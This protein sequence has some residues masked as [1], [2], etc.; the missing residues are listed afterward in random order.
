MSDA[1]DPKMNPWHPMSDPVD[2]KHVQKAQEELGECVSALAR[3]GMQGI[4]EAHPETGKVNRRWLEEEIADA[5]A[6][7]QLVKDH[8]ELD[9]GFI[10]AR[11]L[12]KMARLREWHAMA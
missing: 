6:N 12:K 11:K 4:D 2:L 1:T 7:L 5:E 9:E 3:C 10:Y 8:F